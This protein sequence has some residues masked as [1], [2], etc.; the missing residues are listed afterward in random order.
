MGC[1]TRRAAAVVVVNARIV[2]ATVVA[3]VVPWRFCG[4]GRLD[5]LHAA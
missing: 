1:E 2:V 3:S 4:R 5:A